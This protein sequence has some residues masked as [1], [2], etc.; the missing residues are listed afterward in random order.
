MVLYFKR[1][2]LFMEHHC[3]NDKFCS[4]R[5]AT[6]FSLHN[7]LHSLSTKTE[8]WSKQIFQ[9]TFLVILG[10]SSRLILSIVDAV[11]AAV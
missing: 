8:L 10:I 2:E 11:L 5:Q 9:T 6:D 7:I 3:L 1:I 4:T